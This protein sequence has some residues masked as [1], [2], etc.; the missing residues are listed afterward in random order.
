MPRGNACQD[1][2]EAGRRRAGWG[3]ALALAQ[4]SRYSGAMAIAELTGLFLAAFG[5]A[6]IL[7]GASEAVLAGVL[8]LGNASTAAALAVATLGN[9]LGSVVN[10]MLGRFLGS[11]RGHPRFPVPP[12]KFEAYSAAYRRWGFWS[13]ALS[14]VPVIGDP[15]T[16]VAGVMRTPLWIFVPIVG[17]AKLARYLFVAGLVGLA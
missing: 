8:A 7:P 11:L 13:L 5:A 9:T 1:S 12:E 15:L 14:W 6:T 3:L 2:R 4:T 16:V 17:A 10:W